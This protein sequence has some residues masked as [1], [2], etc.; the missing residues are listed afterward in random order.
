MPSRLDRATRILRVQDRMRQLAE[1][2]LAAV[3]RRVR[4]ADTAQA[5]LIHALN[6]ASAFHEPLRATALHRLKTLAVTAQEARAERDVR[7]RQLL[8]RATQHKR[9]EQWVGRLEAEHERDRER[10]DWA[11]RLDRLSAAVEASL[12]PAKSDRGADEPDVSAAATS[13]AGPEDRMSH[14]PTHPDTSTP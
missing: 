14:G 9:T 2:E 1:R 6:E 7:A 10:R 11:E 3:E 12:P 13:P 4:A 5:D 8:D